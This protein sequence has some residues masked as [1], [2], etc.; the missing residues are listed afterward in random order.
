MRWMLMETLPT[1]ESLDDYDYEFS[2]RPIDFQSEK[3]AP[4]IPSTSGTYPGTCVPCQDSITRDVLL[5]TCRPLR[6]VRPAPM[7]VLGEPRK[8]VS[9]VVSRAIGRP[10]MYPGS[11]WI[12]NWL[13][14]DQLALARA[15]LL[16]EV[17]GA[18]VLPM[19]SGQH[20]T[21]MCQC[22]IGGNCNNSCW[23]VHLCRT[24]ASG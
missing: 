11:T 23:D 24:M 3:I 1:Q 20:I 8:A 10:L 7:S 22:R 18:D 21:P 5:T 19:C 2:Y 13:L 17:C 9:Y 16:E 4:P 6:A 15:K 12:L 14:R